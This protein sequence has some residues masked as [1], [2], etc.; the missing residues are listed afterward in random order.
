MM[1]FFNLK[2]AQLT[3]VQNLSFLLCFPEQADSDSGKQLKYS[4]TWSIQN[5]I[6]GVHGESKLSAK[7]EWRRSDQKWDTLQ[8]LSRKK[9][10]YGAT[11]WYQIFI[12]TQKMNDHLLSGPKAADHDLFVWLQLVDHILRQI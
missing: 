7:I 2:T 6:E 1:E 10:R 12:P 8:I 3:I 4:F 11:Q 5:Q 9:F